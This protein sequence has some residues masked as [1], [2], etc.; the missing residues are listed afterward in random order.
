M[1]V[2]EWTAVLA[3][4]F[5]FVTLCAAMLRFYVKAILREFQPNGGNS[6]RD[7]INKIEERQIHIFELIATKDNS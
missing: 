1:T 7:R 5:T 3:V 6:L 4:F 2:S